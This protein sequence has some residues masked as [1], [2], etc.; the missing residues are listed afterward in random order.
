MQRELVFVQQRHVAE[1]CKCLSLS[2]IFVQ[3]G[4]WNNLGSATCQ[5]IKHL[6]RTCK[7][8]HTTSVKTQRPLFACV[9]VGHRYTLLVL[10]VQRVHRIIPH[11]LW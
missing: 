3:S 2:R 9:D 4:G 6:L 7:L 11:S 8:C 10:L 1:Q 5:D